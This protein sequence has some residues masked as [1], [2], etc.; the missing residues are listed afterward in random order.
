MEVDPISKWIKEI[1]KQIRKFKWT[2]IETKYNSTFNHSII[3]DLQLFQYSLSDKIKISKKKI[4]NNYCRFSQ[5]YLYEEKFYIDFHFNINN[6]II[7]ITSHVYYIDNDDDLSEQDSEN[8]FDIRYDDDLSS[9]T[10]DENLFYVPHNSIS[11]SLD[12][13]D[14]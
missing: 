7:E 6:E 1:R 14:I 3:G 12:E 4:S 10:S 8:E 2:K 5:L 11:L 13:D 9:H